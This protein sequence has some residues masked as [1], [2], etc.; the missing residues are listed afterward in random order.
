MVLQT[1]NGA[2]VATNS[3]DNTMISSS[4]QGIFTCRIPDENGRTVEVNVGIYS[5]DIHC[6]HHNV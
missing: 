6:K 3:V 5:N 2:F 1:E 4:N